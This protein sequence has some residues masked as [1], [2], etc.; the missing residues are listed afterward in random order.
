MNNKMNNLK[1][2]LFDNK[3][4][5]LFVVLCLGC[6]FIADTSLSYIVSEVFARFARNACLVLALI[7]LGG[8][9]SIGKVAAI[10]V[11]LS[12]LILRLKKR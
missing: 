11:P 1:K 5:I 7:I 9:K 4:I 6:I 3:V 12:S 8:I 10:L 2:V